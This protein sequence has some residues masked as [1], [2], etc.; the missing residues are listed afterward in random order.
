LSPIRREKKKKTIL[1]NT[2]NWG[3]S[4]DAGERGTGFIRTLQER[5]KKAEKSLAMNI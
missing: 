2:S 5:K 1:T 3:G 4:G